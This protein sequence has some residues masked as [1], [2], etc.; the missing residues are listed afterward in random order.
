MR[1][2]AMISKRKMKPA[3]RHKSPALRGVAIAMLLI[4]TGHAATLNNGCDPFW[5]DKMTQASVEGMQSDIA[6]KWGYGLGKSESLI[7]LSCFDSLMNGV[8]KIN[9]MFDP[10]A[11]ISGIFNQACSALEA[12]AQ[13]QIAYV[14]NRFTDKL[15]NLPGVTVDVTTGPL[16][17]PIKL[18]SLPRPGSVSG[19]ISADDFGLGGLFK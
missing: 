19:T 16:V 4:S 8:R 14:K 11:F 5:D 9:V 2:L 6:R 18:P 17:N 15:P 10:G 12:K 7:E 1:M 3:N 13:Q